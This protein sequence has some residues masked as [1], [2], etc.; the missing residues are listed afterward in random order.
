MANP[1]QFMQEVRTEANKV[2]WPTRRETMI[3]T[4]MVL[5]M[6]FVA[7]AFFVAVDQALHFAVSL[8]LRLGH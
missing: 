8:F 6:V 1:F 5:V 4:G 2:T 7:S 3:T